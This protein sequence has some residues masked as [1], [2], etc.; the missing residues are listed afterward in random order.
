[1]L[2]DTTKLFYIKEL[3]HFV[4]TCVNRPKGIIPIFKAYI[5]ICK[6]SG[7]C[8]APDTLGIKIGLAL[9][10]RYEHSS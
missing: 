5:I 3:Y 2:L 7:F 4:N 6:V 10:S 1:M 8:M 9:L